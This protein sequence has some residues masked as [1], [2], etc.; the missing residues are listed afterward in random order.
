LK[1][2]NLRCAE[3][4]RIGV[5][6]PNGAGKTT[7][8][9]AIAGVFPPT[10]GRILTRGRIVALLE[11]GLGFNGEMTGAENVV[12]A[13]VLLGSTR[14]EAKQ[15]ISRVLKFAE[16]S[17][18]ADVQLKYYSSG[19]TARLA[20]SVAMETTPDILLLD[21]VFAVGDIH[22]IDRAERRI[23]TL[24]ENAKV[25]IIV[26]HNPDFLRKTCTSGVYLDRGQVRAAG[27]IT[28][29]TE[30]YTRSRTTQTSTPVDNRS[31]SSVR[32]TCRVEGYRLIARAEGIPLLGESWVGLFEPGA[33]RDRYLGYHRV[34]GDTDEVVFD[35]DTGV[36][37]QV[38]L[39]RW[40]PGGE[41]LE[42]SCD[43][44]GPS[45]R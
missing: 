16:L 11:L 24:L 4:E 31:Q 26:S 6:G 39:Y 15:L 35:V 12:L 38:R 3:G 45:D 9:R 22:W 17:D 42:A 7:L 29:V 19:M 36:D 1:N 14:S 41:T 44:A 5:M 33:A 10:R 20:F 40:T 18:F 25:V 37:L 2:V 28:K 27:E 32:L 23:Q 34:A 8:L 13:S 43:L 21:E 30:A